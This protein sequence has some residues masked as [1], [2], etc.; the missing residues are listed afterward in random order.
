[1]DLYILSV[2]ILV[3]ALLSRNTGPCV[4]RTV[5]CSESLAPSD[6][7]LLS[8]GSDVYSLLSADTDTSGKRRGGSEYGK[9]KDIST[10]LGR[11]ILGQN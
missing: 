3:V 2:P 4:S 11:L 8:S 1:M 9:K 10:T 6:D 5:S 7:V